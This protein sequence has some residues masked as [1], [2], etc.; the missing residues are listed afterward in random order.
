MARQRMKSRRCLLQWP[1]NRTDWQR[2]KLR[3]LARYN[4]QS[5]RAYLHHGTRSVCLESRL[6][7][8]DRR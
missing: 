1:E 4:L 5:V 2:L 3:D 6:K 8:C 7:A